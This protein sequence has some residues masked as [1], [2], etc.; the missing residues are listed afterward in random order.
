VARRT[1]TLTIRDSP[2]ILCTRT[3]ETER[4][5]EDFA[6]ALRKA[7][8]TIGQHGLSPEEFVRSGL[9]QGR[10]NVSEANKQL[11]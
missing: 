7:A 1:P 8:H 5:I 6:Q 10:L 4:R 2:I 11:R 3:K 9:F